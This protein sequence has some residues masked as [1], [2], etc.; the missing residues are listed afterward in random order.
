MSAL[1]ALAACTE[2]E[3]NTAD[4]SGTVILDG[5]TTLDVPQLAALTESGKAVLI[6][7]RT[8]EEFAQGHI[9][10]AVNM[11]LDSFDPATVPHVPGK[12][13]VL[14]CRSGKRSLAAAEQLAVAT[15]SAVHMDGGIL[16]WEAAGMRVTAAE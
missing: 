5:V 12:Q 2:T 8:P 13:T 14:Y 1:L 15:G 10:G 3:A 9:A 6:D 11:P 7:V 16:A 4:V